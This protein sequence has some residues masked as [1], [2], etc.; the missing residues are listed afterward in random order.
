M[1]TEKKQVRRREYANYLINKQIQVFG[2]MSHHTLGKRGERRT[3]SKDGALD[4]DLIW[5]KEERSG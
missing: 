2:I 3:A 5:E 1:S 4:S